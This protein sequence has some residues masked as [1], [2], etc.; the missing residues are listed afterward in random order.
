MQ[1]GHSGRQRDRTIQG[2]HGLLVM[3]QAHQAQAQI[4]EHGWVIG[5]GARCRLQ[6]R[7]GLFVLILGKGRQPTQV[8]ESRVGVAGSG[9]RGQRGPGFVVLARLKQCKRAG[10]LV[11]LAQ[12]SPSIGRT[13]P[14]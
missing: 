13:V 12:Y 2:R 4:A 1:I 5:Q 11:V 14:L 8:V 6:V 3:S 9:Q 10:Q 7:A